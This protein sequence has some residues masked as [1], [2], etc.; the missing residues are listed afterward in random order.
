MGRNPAGWSSSDSSTVV[1]SHC[2][3]YDTEAHGGFRTFSAP[4]T[5]LSIGIRYKLSAFT[6]T[7]PR[8]LRS[9]N[10]AAAES[11]GAFSSNRS[12]C[13]TRG[14]ASANS[15]PMVSTFS[16]N[17]R[18]TVWFDTLG[19][20]WGSCCSHHLRTPREK[21]AGCLRP[22]GSSTVSSSQSSVIVDNPH[23]TNN[24]SSF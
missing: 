15:N 3:R 4:R 22:S 23:S 7:R 19:E 21:Q 5:A 11:L 1:G 16:C 17:H 8:L 6:A 13:H 9:R 12:I 18:L 20:G 14:H 10:R 24:Q 2:L